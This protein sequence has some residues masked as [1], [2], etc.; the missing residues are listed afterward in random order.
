MAGLKPHMNKT[1]PMGAAMSF[2]MMSDKDFNR[3]SRLIYEKCGINLTPA[4][5]TMLSSRL[6][7]RIRH[8]NMASF[9]EY[10]EYVSMGRNC[11]EELVQM[12]DVVSTNKTD[13]FREPK[14]FNFLFNEALPRLVDAGLWKPGKKL[15]IWSAGC[16]SGEEP[17]TVAMVL[18][19]YTAKY[20]G[21][22]FAILASDIS[23]RV[24]EKAAQGIYPEATVAP[25]P[26]PMKHKYLMRGK[27]AQAGFCRV[28]PELRNR[29]SFRRINLNGHEG[30]NIKTR[31]DI[32]FCRNV[33]IYFDRP[34]QEKLF[35]KYYHQ[36]V[37]GGYLFIG[38]SET[39]NG[40]NDQFVPVAGS[41]YKKNGRPEKNL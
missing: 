22:D 30:F 14:H 41:T 33:I 21:L 40:I 13:F 5:K 20:Q 28:V 26:N 39:L 4:K 29:V 24:L 7:K 6:K 27:G 2:T 34:T 12:I 8:L 37:P 38:H 3:F 16:S 17:Y 11:D 31:M 9:S 18:S 36:L 25:V 19:E 35:D 32:I 1:M 15:N 10:Y 23:T